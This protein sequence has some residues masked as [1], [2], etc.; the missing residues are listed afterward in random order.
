MHAGQREPAGAHVERRDVVG[1][2]D[3]ADVRR[4]VADHR[5]HDADELVGEPVVGE[6]ARRCRSGGPCG[7]DATTS[8][9]GPG[10]GG[11]KRADGDR[12]APSARSAGSRVGLRR[13]SPALLAGLC[14][15]AGQ[16]GV[17]IVLADAVRLADPERRARR[18]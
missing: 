5:L 7:G 9:G 17:E 12:P 16:V 15:A 1:E 4:D 14:V 13:L 10:R 6:E 11:A 3:D 8:T 2:V 18:P